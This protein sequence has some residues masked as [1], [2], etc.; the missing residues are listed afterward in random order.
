MIYVTTRQK[1]YEE[2]QIS[3]L[4]IINNVPFEEDLGTKGS[5]GTVTRVY[6]EAPEN[7]LRAINVPYMIG[8]LKKFNETYD[9]L[10]KVERKT[11]YR[12]FSIPKRSGGL[13]PIDAPCDEL[14][15]ALGELKH[16][17]ADKFGVLY[18][19]AA[20]A[21]VTGR[22]ITQV[23]Y[24]HQANKSNWFL[25]TDFSGFFPS[26]TLDFAMSMIEKVFPI[27][28][29]CK[30]EEGKS[31]L[32]K[33]LSL[34]FLNNQLPQGTVLSPTLTNMIM[35]PMDH[36][37]FNYFAHKH[38]VYTR[39]ADDICVSCVQKFDARKTLEYMKSVL[40]K[41]NAPWT[42]KPE[43]THFI[44]NKASTSNWILGLNLNKDNNITVGWERKKFFKVMTTNL[45]MD[46]KHHVRWPIDDVQHYQGLLSYYKM[47]EK[48][49]FTNLLIHFEDKFR[50][51]MDKVIKYHMAT[52]VR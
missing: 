25:K 42:I 9:N 21:Y 12:H 20:F 49:Y 6:E 38:M 14:Q 40:R 13:R 34:G 26:T 32:R 22:S 17:L 43:K 44:T 1:E 18:H 46:Y 10:F 37:M 3:W 19:T 5:A 52:S 29:I 33:A 4:D 48:E 47:V 24:K 15:Y 30:V 27:S 23:D 39:Y 7:L 35:I 41:W 11:L 50:V 36:E 2:K 45:I 51:K 16:I 31:E 8:Q 28:E